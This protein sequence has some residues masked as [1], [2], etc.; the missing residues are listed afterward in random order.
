MDHVLSRKDQLA[1]QPEAILA[2]IDEWSSRNQMLMTVGSGP[3]RGGK[4]TE[5]IS[6]AKPGVMVELGG[7]IGYSAI[8]FASAVGREGGRRYISLESD[9]HY[10]ELARSLISLA[11][12]DGF[13]EVVV[14]P[15]SE[16]MAELAAQGVG[17]DLLFIDHAEKL[18]APDLRLAEDLG[19]LRAGALVVADNVCGR[20]AK[21]Y[22]EA[23]EAVDEAGEEVGR[24]INKA[25][26][27]ESSVSY[28]VLPTGQTVRNGL[29]LVSDADGGH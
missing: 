21:D 25:K 2:A 23:M 20:A 29:F 4:V 10:A 15:A 28:F 1:G 13:A 6:G 22:K 12:L 27:Y 11:G 9:A 17:I 14:G 26:T 7:Y 16:S 18:Y 24:G 19:L 3:E 5:A 8:K